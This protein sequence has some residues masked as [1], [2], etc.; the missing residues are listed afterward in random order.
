MLMRSNQFVM[1]RDV[2]KLAA[3]TAGKAH[4]YPFSLRKLDLVEPPR[5]VGDGVKGARL[6]QC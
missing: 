3:L 1:L 5:R 4:A 2:A 6:R